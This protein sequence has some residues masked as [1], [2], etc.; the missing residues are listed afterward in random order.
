[1]SKLNPYEVFLAGQEPLKVLA[2]TSARVESILHHLGPDRANT[3]PAP[4]KWSARQ[5]A[6]H[7]ADCEIAFA[8]RLRQTLAENNHT[9]QP[10]DQEKWAAQYAAYSAH[11]AL[12]AFAA[13]RNWNLALLRAL[14]PEANATQVTH[15]ERGTMTFR[16]IVETM[17]GHDL[18][19]LGQLESIMKKLAPEP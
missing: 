16:T 17:A 1:M 9:I 15:P 10:F 18:N 6:C 19:H 3:A 14:S 12:A 13:T 8:F 5:I 4:G 7:L 2:A 11:E